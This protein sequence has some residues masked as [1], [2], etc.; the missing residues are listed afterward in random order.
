MWLLER[1]ACLSKAILLYI[2]KF[3]SNVDIKGN[4]SIDRECK[5]ENIGVDIPSFR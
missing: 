4:P 2:M 1:M 3:K 5:D